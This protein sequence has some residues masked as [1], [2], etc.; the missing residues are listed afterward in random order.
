MKGKLSWS[1]PRE[2]FKLYQEHDKL[3]IVLHNKIKKSMQ[4]DLIA[5]KKSLS[6]GIEEDGE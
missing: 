2:L 4:N 1:S 3:L 5:L 6:I